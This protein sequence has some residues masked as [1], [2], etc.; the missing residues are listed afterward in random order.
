MKKTIAII[1]VM[2][3]CAGTALGITFS[4]VVRDNQSTILPISNGLI[5]TVRNGAATVLCDESENEHGL[6]PGECT[7]SNV[8]VVSIQYCDGSAQDLVDARISVAFGYPVS[9]TIVPK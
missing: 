1:S 5:T 9:S 8:C 6:D 2:S 7:A 3:L 4:S